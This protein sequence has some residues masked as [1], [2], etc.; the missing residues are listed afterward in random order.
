MG[1]YYVYVD[2]SL[3]AMCIDLSVLAVTGFDHMK[4]ITWNI[5]NE[6][7]NATQPQYNILIMMLLKTLECKYGAY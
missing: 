2:Q 3:Y 4:G 7:P 5:L 6:L 1:L